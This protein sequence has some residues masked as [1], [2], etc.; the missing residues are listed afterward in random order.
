MFFE[1]TA[2]SD[3]YTDEIYDS[4]SKFFQTSDLN[5]FCYNNLVIPFNNEELQ[6]VNDKGYESNLSFSENNRNYK[7]K[8]PSHIKKNSELINEKTFLGKKLEKEQFNNENIEI[9]H[10]YENNNFLANQF[11][12]EFDENLQ[13]IENCQNNIIVKEVSLIEIEKSPKYNEINKKNTK[14][15]GRKSVVEKENG[16]I[17]SHTKDNEDNKIHKIKSFFW[18]SLYKYLTKSFINDEE[19]LKIEIGINK[20]LK[21]DFNLKLLKTSLKEIYNQFNISEKYKLKKVETNE[22]LI[23]RIYSENQETEVIKILNLT[24]GEAF[25]IFRRNLKKSFG[26]SDKLKKKI[27]N[28]NILNQNYFEDAEVFINKIRECAKKKG[29]SEE[30]IEEYL[31]DIKRLILGYEN[32]F[33]QKIGREAS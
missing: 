33:Y 11:I 23:K 25:E 8:N 31:D 1:S 32:W 18:K 5:N 7:Y 28:T 22:R 2:F 20:S 19:L 29:E 30:K 12:D 13:I 14:K 26:L 10:N 9:F 17:G 15:F 21:R 27:E 3:N 24:Y 6:T 16:K 4:F